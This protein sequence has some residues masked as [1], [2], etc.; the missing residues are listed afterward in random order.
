M[1]RGQTGIALVI[2]GV[3][4]IIAVIG[5]VLLFTRASKEAQGAVLT[6]LSIGNMYGGGNVQEG[7]GIST[8]Y[9][10]AQYDRTQGGG[11]V[12]RSPVQEVPGYS[13]NY[14]TAVVNTKGS[15]T[16]AYIISGKFE[17]GVRSGFA[18]IADAPGCRWSL[19]TGAKMGDPRTNFNCYQVP[20]KGPPNGKTA[21][22]FF[23]PDSSAEPRPGKS[24]LGNVGG[25]VYCYANSVGAEG[26]KPNSEDLIR[27]NLLNAV[28]S[29][30]ANEKYEWTTT[31]VNG[32]EVPV[33][34]ISAKTFPFP[35]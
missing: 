21:V 11:Y 2:L 3:I 17:N 20:N 5:L 6:D 16:P 27:Q 23:P 33:C 31:F 22:G 7:Q 12:L 25:D 1:K 35:Q 32:L 4:A 15:R 19:I 14:P 18:T 28:N 13:S 30:V 10:T 9:P 26:Q 34:W 24:D 29:G 8:L